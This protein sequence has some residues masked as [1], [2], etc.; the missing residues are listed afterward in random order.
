MSLT[1]DALIVLTS[2][3]YASLA[4]YTKVEESFNL[5]ATHDVL[6][7][8]V[9]PTNLPK[10]DHFTFSGP[11]PRTFIGA[12]VLAWATQLCLN[13]GEW[14]GVS[15]GKFDA[16]VVLR[17]V[18]A[19]INAIG[20]CLL[21]RAVSR[22]FGRLTSVMFAL[23]SCTQFH[24]PFWMGRTLP[25]MFAL[26]PVNVALCLML[27]R[28]PNS[29][30]PSPGA[31]RGAL[32]LLT[33]ATVVFRSELLLLVGPVALQSAFQYLPLLDV[34]KTGLLAGSA[35]VALTVAVDSYFW[36]QWPLWP[37]LY[38][39]YFNVVRGK[40]SEWGVMPF[41]VYVS[42][43]LPKLLLSSLPLSLFACLIDRRIRAIMA[44]YAAFV[45]L[46]SGLGHK[47]WRFVIYTVPAFN[48]A[49]ARGATWLVGRRKG[50]LFGRLCFLAVMGML[51][52]NCVA[53]SLLARSSFANYPGG[54]ALSAFNK[55][56]EHEDYLHVHISNLAAQTGASLFLQSH[57]SPHL[58]LPSVQDSV[59]AHKNW[60]YDKTEGLSLADLTA[61]TR[62]THLIAEADA[63][64][65]SRSWTRVA[66][67]DGFDGW[68]LNLDVR[69][70]GL[71]KVLEMKKSEKL[72][73]L[74]RAV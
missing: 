62:I 17:L 2:F 23:L 55:F 24:L 18:L 4:P 3:A 1:L 15:A 33:F 21:R 20:L 59:Y 66:S 26:L 5:H 32:A 65:S 35:S 44:P 11:L 31:V 8:G 47:E 70:A 56:F 13:A 45:A 58:S 25:N 53:T 38:S 69:L 48:V 7:Y 40:S 6:M 29:T 14:M 74:K 28:A 73:I 60:T 19:S 52:A 43:F 42:S 22:R 68:R 34:I 61:D 63:L 72:V 64:P 46:I 30:R 12:V 54:A 9:G 67:V 37:E 36:Q 16:Q 27:D 41:H 10:Y 39:L 71:T 51:A 50:T 57:A 49:A